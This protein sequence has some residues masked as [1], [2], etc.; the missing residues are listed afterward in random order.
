MSSIW[1][2]IFDPLAK[3]LATPTPDYNDGG[4]EVFYVEL[5]NFYKEDHP[6]YKVVVGEFQVLPG[7]RSV[8]LKF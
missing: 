5:G 7:R 3:K 2:S 1:N 4:V 8:V 6:F